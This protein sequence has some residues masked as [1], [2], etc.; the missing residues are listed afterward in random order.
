[1]PAGRVPANPTGAAVRVDRLSEWSTARVTVQVPHV[2]H[3]RWR[4]DSRYQTA[5][6]RVG[7]G[8]SPM[9]EAARGHEA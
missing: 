4:A 7:G 8:S 2:E 5:R 3:A 6:V 9:V 1:M